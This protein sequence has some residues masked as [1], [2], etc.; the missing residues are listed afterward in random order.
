MLIMFIKH[1]TYLASRPSVAILTLTRTFNTQT[2]CT[3]IITITFAFASCDMFE[4]LFIVFTHIPVGLSLYMY[5][6]NRVYYS[7][8]CIMSILCVCM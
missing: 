1:Y 3:L 4:H 8:V 2:I 5:S 7:I 6:V